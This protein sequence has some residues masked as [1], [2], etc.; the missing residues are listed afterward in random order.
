MTRTGLAACALLPRLSQTPRCRQEYD[1]EYVSGV[2][3]LRSVSSGQCSMIRSLLIT[4]E[5][6]LQTQ[7]DATA[8]APSGT[9]NDFRRRWGGA[10]SSWERAIDAARVY[11]VCSMGTHDAHA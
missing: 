5:A 10:K 8:A 3:T 11:H 1:L 2:S 6:N 9:E 4:T 7:F